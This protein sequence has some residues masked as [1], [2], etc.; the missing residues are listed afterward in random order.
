[1][2]NEYPYRNLTDLN[3]DYILNAIKTFQNE[4]TNFVSINA[5]KYANPIQWN[6]VSQYEKNTIVIDPL[7]G[8]AYISVA[9]VPSGVALTREEYWTVVFDLGSFVVRAAKNFT[10]R[11]EADTTLTA[12]FTTPAGGW[13]V[14]G[15]TLYRAAVN[16]TAGDQYIVGSNITHFTMEMETQDIRNII[17]LLS[18]LNTNDKSSIVAAIN[19]IIETITTSVSNLEESITSEAQARADADTALQDAIDDEAQARTDAD[20]TLQNAIDDEVQARTD[21]INNRSYYGTPEMYGAIGDGVAD[22]TAAINL[23]VANHNNVIFSPNK[24][25]MISS[26]ILLHRMSFIDLNQSTIQ[27]ITA[28]ITFTH[29]TN[30]APDALAYVHIANGIIKGPND[31]TAGDGSK[32]IYVAAFYSYFD[33]LY[34]QNLD[35]GIHNAYRFQ[36][37]SISLNNNIYSKIRCYNCNDYGILCDHDSDGQLLT[38]WIGSDSEPVSGHGYGVYINNGAGWI[39]DDLHIYVTGHSQLHVGSAAA[40]CISNSYFEGKSKDNCLR[41]IANGKCTVS[42]CVINCNEDMTEHAGSSAISLGKT[43]TDPY[44]LYTFNNII[45][46][47]IDTFTGS[48]ANPIALVRADNSTNIIVEANNFMV[49]NHDDNE[50]FKTGCLNVNIHYDNFSTKGNMSECSAG[51][52][53]SGHKSEFLS[54]GA[55]SFTF[56]MPYGSPTT[57]RPRGMAKVYIS[58]GS[59]YGTAQGWAELTLYFRYNNAYLLDIGKIETDGV[60]ITSATASLSGTTVTVTL[61]QTIYGTI[62]VDKY[63]Y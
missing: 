22:D 63:I 62:L 45:F 24:T 56:E 53:N 5:I 59:G 34:F 49:N 9:P 16:I 36:N 37:P 8:T 41:L 43:G 30:L 18:D 23:A 31:H 15:D 39:L 7:T 14:W 4:V 28:T 11:Y 55:S 17:G 3:L 26:P 48:Y 57:A 21:E 6:I 61:N 1:M 58:G 42:N 32:G 13:V 29:D 19:E 10:N 35:I 47:Y 2:F 52:I 12:T 38:C 20:T 25:Y 40:T 60:V 46:G 33:N 44:A 27:Q 50:L 54:S 51:R